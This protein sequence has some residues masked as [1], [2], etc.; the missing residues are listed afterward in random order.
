LSSIDRFSTGLG[1]QRKEIGGKKTW[2]FGR[3]KQEMKVGKRADRRFVWDRS[4]V[5][6]CKNQEKAV[7]GSGVGKRKGQ[8]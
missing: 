8:K 5:A 6:I 7:K 1:G 2:E 4:I 3:R